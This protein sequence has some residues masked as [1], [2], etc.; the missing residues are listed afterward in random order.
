MP[1]R[2]SHASNEVRAQQRRWAAAGGQTLDAAG[3][4]VTHNDNLFVPLQGNTLIDFSRGDGGEVGRA[5]KRGKLQAVHSSS[6]L[7]CNVFDYWKGRDAGPLA[8]ALHLGSNIAE[9]RFEQKFP[10]GVSPRSPNL[11]VVL[12]LTNGSLTAVE[13]KFLEPYGA[14]AKKKII[15]AKYFSEDARRWQAAGLPG[16]QRLAEG[17][18]DGKVCF[19][20]LDAPQLLKHLLGVAQQSKAWELLYLW[21]DPKADTAKEH[22]SEIA[23]FAERLGE[24]FS[25][26][27]SASYSQIFARLQ[28]DVGENH[29]EYVSYLKARYFDA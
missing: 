13:S 1:P 24:D 29:R 14:S 3:Y 15:Q 23:D 18:R 5:G 9:I 19:E 8:R 26:F 27:R 12:S 2:R 17:I 22:E 21:F 11:D 10:T 28:K 4:C 6:A 7:A 25:R 16:A 20:Y